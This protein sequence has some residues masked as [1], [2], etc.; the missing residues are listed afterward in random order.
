MGQNP[1]RPPANIPIP[2]KIGSKMGGEFTDF[3][4]PQYDSVSPNQS[5]FCSRLGAE[6][7]LPQATA[8]AIRVFWRALPFSGLVVGQ[9]QVP[10]ME[11]R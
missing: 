11:P 4:R 8:S 5:A 9:K 2:T 1:N 7:V 10:K 6:A 3:A